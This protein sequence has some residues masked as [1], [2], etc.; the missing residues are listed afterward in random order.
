M[1]IISDYI[2]KSAIASSLFKGQSIFKLKKFYIVDESSTKITALVNASESAK[3]YTVT[4]SLRSQN[5][6][7]TTCSCP[8]SSA[9]ICKHSIAILLY[10][11]KDTPK[12][13]APKFN[14]AKVELPYQD[15]TL[16]YVLANSSK[17]FY[18]Q[19]GHYYKR[20]FM[21]QIIT[22]TRKEKNFFECTV[23]LWS[24]IGKVKLALNKNV[25]ETSC[26][27]KDTKV[28]LCLH[29]LLAIQFLTEDFTKPNQ[30]AE[31]M[32]ADEQKQYIAA[33]YGFGNDI[34]NFDKYFDYALSSLTGDMKA[35]AKIDGLQ[36]IKANKGLAS[37]FYKNINE[38]TP[39]LQKT[40]S[41]KDFTHAFFFG[42]PFEY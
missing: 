10:M 9:G 34:E 23:S 5:N 42:E 20:S 35:V 7:N 33:Q 21:N 24:G 32:G 1:S 2:K 38:A 30:L 22:I 25:L 14:Q 13:I 17:A 27:C 15:L 37:L 4:V 8:Y 3:N 11:D 26:N 36:P 29:K 28:A 6:I 18:D 19:M 16:E 41:S 39:I 40:E 31:L 12:Q